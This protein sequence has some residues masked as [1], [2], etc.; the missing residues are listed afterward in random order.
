MAIE[1]RAMTVNSSGTVLWEDEG[2]GSFTC[3]NVGLGQYEVT[4]PTTFLSDSTYVAFVTPQS[5]TGQTYLDRVSACVL[6]R[7]VNSCTVSLSSQV[8]PPVKVDFGFNL[9]IIGE[10]SVGPTPPTPVDYI[11]YYGTKA[12]RST[13]N[14]ATFHWTS[15]PGFS[16]TTP[17]PF[18]TYGGIQWPVTF[19]RGILVGTMMETAGVGTNRYMANENSNSTEGSKSVTSGWESSGTGSS[20]DSGSVGFVDIADDDGLVEVCGTVD[21]NG[22]VLWVSDGSAWTCNRSATGYYQMTAPYEIEGK[23]VKTTLM[24]G[25]ST[26][27]ANGWGAFHTDNITDTTFT[28]NIFASLSRLNAPFSFRIIRRI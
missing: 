2:S 19:D 21:L 3:T 5:N 27:Y 13:G 15:S 23:W 17:G 12:R 6:Q 24:L 18:V 26:S 28:V 8:T 25:Q 7:D 11:L 14:G 9:E 1:A 16:S 4:Y 20:Q 22:N 10:T